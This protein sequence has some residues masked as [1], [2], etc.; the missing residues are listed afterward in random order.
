MN[1][2]QCWAST[3]GAYPTVLL[4]SANNIPRCSIAVTLFYPLLP[5]PCH[6]RTG[7]FLGLCDWYVGIVLNYC[8]Y[9]VLYLG[10]YY[11]TGPYISFPHFENSNLGKLPCIPPGVREGGRGVNVQHDLFSVESIPGPQK[12]VK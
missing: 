11:D 1:I 6:S 8:Q 9:G 10:S 12:Y 2:I 7:I 4:A 5:C 3:L